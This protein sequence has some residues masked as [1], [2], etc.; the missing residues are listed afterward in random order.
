VERGQ[1]G[2]GACPM[3]TAGANGSPRIR[4]PAAVLV[5][6]SQSRIERSDVRTAAEEEHFRLTRGYGSD[7]DSLH[8]LLSIKV[9]AYSPWYIEGQIPTRARASTDASREASSFGRLPVNHDT[10]A[11]EHHARK[12][13]VRFGRRGLR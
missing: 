11:L 12:G 8:P 3:V 9:R 6:G 7:T 5:R 4:G 1:R 13:A 10:S 2:P